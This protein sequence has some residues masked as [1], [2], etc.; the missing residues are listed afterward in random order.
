MICAHSGGMARKEKPVLCHERPVAKFGRHMTLLFVTLATHWAVTSLYGGAVAAA[1]LCRLPFAQLR[2][3]LLPTSP[4]RT[5][6]IG[7]PV[8]CVNGDK[9]STRL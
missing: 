1:K 8:Q 5:M 3:Q 4:V 9:H 6:Y 7:S 2:L